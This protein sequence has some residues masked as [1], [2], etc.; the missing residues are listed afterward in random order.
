MTALGGSNRKRRNRR[1]I[2]ASVAILLLL[3]TLLSSANRIIEPILR[4]RLH[5]LIIK[6][7][8]SL[9][10]YQ[11]GGLKVNFF[12]GNVEINNLH[13]WVDSV[14]YRKLKSN[15]ALPSLTMELRLDKGRVVG[16]GV[17][18]LVLNKRI[19][20]SE[21]ISNDA[22][23]VLSRHARNKDSLERTPPLWKSIQPV[24]ESISINKVNLD[25]VK[26][27][28]KN[29]D[30][31]ASLKLQFDRCVALFENILID[32]TSA[33][34]T[35]RIA[36]AKNV[37]MQFYDLKFRT[38]DSTYKM[39][40]EVID[41]RSAQKKLEIKDFK[42]Q[43][44]LEGEDFF[45]NAPVQKTRYL[46]EFK[47]ILL[48]NL[49]LDKF[50]HNDIILADSVLIREPD[51]AMETDK[52]P[53]PT[54]D[55]R[56]G[57]YPHQILMNTKTEIRIGG[58]R[59]SN[60]KLTTTERAPKTNLKGTITISSLNGLISNVT[61]DPVTIGRNSQ[62][63]ALMN[64]KLFGSS[65]LEAKFTFPLDTQEGNFRVEGS[66]RNVNAAQL[67]PVAVP[68]ANVRLES[69]EVNRLGFQLQ[70]DNYSTKGNVQMKYNNLSLVLLK[71]DEE[72][73]QV[74]TKKF[75]TKILNR[76]TIHPANPEAGIE[77]KATDVIYARVSTKA[78]FGVVWKTIFF[79]M[80]DIMIKTGRYE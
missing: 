50:I 10:V 6:G 22:Q 25:G 18:A 36:F 33:A 42:L 11:L 12:G 21:I 55:N 78:F 20:L 13:I 46:V 68:L 28:Y 37:S 66:I 2:I 56:I 19:E 7:S 1:I 45:K 79:G 63:I 5:T 40:A 41:Y 29:A 76:Y 60:G 23:L 67:N 31:S 34:D 65:P 64:A 17:F 54:M 26:L 53:P 43:P 51:I 30:T 32:S 73:G 3:T 4:D 16:L 58:I 35:T 70:G 49:W 39:K 71:R 61:N 15:E 72:T 69:L 38:L 80:Q 74:S 9:Y 14:R 75:L 44:T 59:V 48:T 52:M 24:I 47:S 62:C 27:L 57:K 8:D 77:R